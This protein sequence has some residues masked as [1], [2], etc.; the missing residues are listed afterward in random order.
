MAAITKANAVTHKK[1]KNI[2]AMA[3]FPHAR[4]ALRV[5]VVVAKKSSKRQP[6]NALV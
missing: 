4:K 2:A 3:L 1:N 5:A 6:K